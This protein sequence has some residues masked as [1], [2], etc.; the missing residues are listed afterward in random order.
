MSTPRGD[1]VTLFKTAVTKKKSAVTFFIHLISPKNHS[2]LTLFAS[3]AQ[4]K[5]IYILTKATTLP[6]GNEDQN[7]FS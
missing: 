4:R 2:F 3:P 6:I 5:K 1:A 7:G